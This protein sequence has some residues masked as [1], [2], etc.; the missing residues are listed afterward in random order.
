MSW[1]D[2]FRPRPPQP[3]MRVAFFNAL[4]YPAQVRLEAPEADTT[5]ATESNGRCGPFVFPVSMPTANLFVL[6]E[7]FLE[8]APGYQWYGEVVDIPPAPLY[9]DGNPKSMEWWVTPID[10]AYPRPLP[11]TWYQFPKL[12][13]PVGLPTLVPEGSHFRQVDGGRWTGIEA[14][15][16]QAYQKFLTGQDLTACFSQLR[17]LGFNTIRV[18]G[19]CRNL[20]SLDPTAFPDF[21]TKLPAFVRFAARYGL[22]TDFVVFPD[23]ALVMPD[24]D[25]QHLHWGLVGHALFPVASSVL[26]S[27]QN[28]VDQPP[29][30]ID[31]T[32]FNTLPGLLCSRG[33]WGAAGKDVVPHMDWTELHTNN[34]YQWPRKVG[35]NT[36]ELGGVGMATEN[37][38]P[39]RDGTL[40]HF[41][42]AAAGA[43]LL[44]AGS[45]FHSIPGRTSDVLTG[46]DLECADAWVMGSELVPLN[47]QDGPYRHRA[48][49]EGPN[50]GATGERVY[51]RGNDPRCIVRIRP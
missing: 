9:D 2:W 11:D 7:D 19:M 47:C 22:R 16:F 31:Y 15:S 43:A 39:D 14:S 23:C 25:Q 6:D 44:C 45:C 49:L 48:D 33:S 51:Q 46:Y 29:N 3:K 18:F 26:V 32:K 27:L 21:Y 37:T 30:K 12:L 20:F 42:D 50:A 35:H 41:Y 1:W 17:D 10:P 24:P 8:G 5:L 36:W 13:V 38:R 40:H 34:A 28:E 4:P